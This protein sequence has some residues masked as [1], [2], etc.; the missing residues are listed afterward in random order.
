M[1][2]AL[3]QGKTKNHEPNCVLDTRHRQYRHDGM[4]HDDT[5]PELACDHHELAG[6]GNTEAAI[7]GLGNEE[8]II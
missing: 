1:D 3:A 8:F 4:N 2:L 7:L 5:G 6:Y